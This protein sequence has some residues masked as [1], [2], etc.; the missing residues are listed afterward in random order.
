MISTSPFPQKIQSLVLDLKRNNGYPIEYT[1]MALLSAFSTAVG[2]TYKLEVNDNWK[3]RTVFYF[4]IVGLP[5]TLKTHP[6]NFAY[7]PLEEYDI[8]MLEKCKQDKKE[9]E[10]QINSLKKS[11]N[12]DYTIPEMPVCK[13][14]ILDDVTPEVVAKDTTITLRAFA[15]R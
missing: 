14:T 5:A 1:S 10:Q 6:V 9:F 12:S 15:L 7:A 13:R 11:K 8:K 4:V 3:A 2:N